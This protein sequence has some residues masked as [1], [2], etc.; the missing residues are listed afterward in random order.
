MHRIKL[1]QVGKH[2]I[3]FPSIQALFVKQDPKI[4]KDKW[5]MFSFKGK[6]PR[7]ENSGGCNNIVLIVWSSSKVS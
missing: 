3:M 2:C 5:Q 7:G 1:W 4:E 6:L